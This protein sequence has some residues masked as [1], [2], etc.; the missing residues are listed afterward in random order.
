[1][2]ACGGAVFARG[3]LTDFL[4]NEADARR[5]KRTTQQ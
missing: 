5:K 3:G 1:V 4:N 2:T